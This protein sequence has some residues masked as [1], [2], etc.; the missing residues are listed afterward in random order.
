MRSL[1]I[2]I[3]FLASILALPYGCGQN[4]EP[5]KADMAFDTMVLEMRDLTA[6]IR[7]I[8]LHRADHGNRVLQLAVDAFAAGSAEEVLVEFVG[9]AMKEDDQ[10]VIT[11]ERRNEVDLTHL[12]TGLRVRIK[13]WEVGNGYRLSVQV[14]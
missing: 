6:Q 10:I 8:S 1:V 5:T 9:G 11:A 3:V 7:G 4:Y 2:V 12:D 13:A 14:D